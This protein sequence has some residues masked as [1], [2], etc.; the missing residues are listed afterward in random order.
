MRALLYAYRD[1]NEK[2]REPVLIPGLNEH[3]K[4]VEWHQ[5][6]KR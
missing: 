6:K 4:L 3:D 5:N 1:N 2:Q